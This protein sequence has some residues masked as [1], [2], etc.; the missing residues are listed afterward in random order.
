[1]VTTN[2]QHALPVAPN[3]LNRDFTACRPNEKWLTD[4]TYIATAEGWLY[5]AVVM[6][7]FS[8]KIVGWAMEAT[9]ES[10]RPNKFGVEKA[11]QMAVQNRQNIQGLLHHS[12]RGSQYAGQQPYQ[13]LLDIYHLQVSMSR[14]GNCLR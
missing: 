8:R 13:K 4:M 9:L 14:T 10:S 5:L 2:S 7:L 1:V 11:F 3:R 12:D 6:D